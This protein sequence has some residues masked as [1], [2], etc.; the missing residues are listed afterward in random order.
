MP[1]DLNSTDAA[2]IALHVDA[3]GRLVLQM[4]G[5]APVVDVAPVRCFP[6]TSPSE[7]VSLCDEQGHEVACIADLADLRPDVRA[8]I[9]QELARREFIPI[10]VRILDISQGSEPTTWRVLTDRGESRFVLTSEDHVRRLG[11]RGVLITDADGVRYRVPDSG[12]LDA[13]GSNLLKRYL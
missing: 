9:E 2:T 5:A 13:H 4:P 3:F 8:L 12:S 1:T 6:F 11:T 7:R 10:I